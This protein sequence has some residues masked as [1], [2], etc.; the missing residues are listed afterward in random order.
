MCGRFVSR[1]DAALERE[2]SLV[3]PPF[4]MDD[5]NVAPTATIPVVYESDEG[6]V[7][8]P[9]RW[10]LVPASARGKVGKYPNHN[11]RS[12]KL[13][14]WPWHVAWARG[15]RCLIPAWYVY[16][17]QEVEGQS[18][19]QRWAI[20][21]ADQPVMALAGIWDVSR[22]DDGEIEIV[23]TTMLT[24]RA[25]QLMRR[26]HNSGKNRH[27]MIVPI[28]PPQFQVWLNG[29]VEEAQ[30]LIQPYPSARMEAWPVSSIVT[31]DDLVRSGE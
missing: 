4:E 24:M 3:R 10:G 19:K 30:A 27:R 18:K 21:L 2:F 22:S 6:R 1:V 15:Q 16:E 11:A 29:S 17:W 28:E 12:D 7:C 20:R 14:K 9:M 31:E 25:N 13:D 23:S 5:I 26:I 8:D